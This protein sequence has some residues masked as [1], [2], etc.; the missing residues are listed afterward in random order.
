M[1]LHPPLGKTAAK[2]LVALD[3]NQDGSVSPSEV[4]KYAVS[5]GADA[6]AASKEFTLLDL[7]N[8]G[9]IDASELQDA[10]DGVATA[11]AARTAPVMMQAQ[12]TPTLQTSMGQSGKA[13][14]QAP[15]LNGG[16]HSFLAAVSK[17]TPQFVEQQFNSLAAS[18]AAS[19][20]VEQLSFEARKEKA[21]EILERHASELRANATT[22]LAM[23]EQR[24]LAA[25]M[26][27]GEL[28]ANDLMQSLTKIEDD[29]KH[30]EVQ[31]AKL[32]ARIQADLAWSSGFMA[33]A[34]AALKQ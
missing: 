15:A 25:G 6:K 11:Q 20:V 5:Q 29:A 2:T 28:K 16:T 21:A 8:D 13:A 3:T 14:D 9:A 23:T 17:L 4:V 12:F 7:N 19:S 30:N 26:K 10:L 31:A 24:A 33:V 32:H 27:A 18:T 34:D 1:S 22:L